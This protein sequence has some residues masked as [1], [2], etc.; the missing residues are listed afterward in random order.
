MRRKVN[1]CQQPQPRALLSPKPHLQVCLEM[2]LYPSMA[3]SLSLRHLQKLH[4]LQKRLVLP[5]LALNH[6]PLVLKLHQ[7][8]RLRLNPRLSPMETR[9]RLAPLLLPI[10]LRPP[11]LLPL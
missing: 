2:S 10:G 5:N 6:R 1:R 7:L 8:R 9:G 11:K 4:R 3:H